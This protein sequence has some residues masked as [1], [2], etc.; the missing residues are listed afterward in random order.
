MFWFI[1]FRKSKCAQ[2]GTE[3]KE[4]FYE[5]GGKKFCCQECK[6]AYRKERKR[7]GKCH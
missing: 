6:K 1:K 4:T 2:C 5:W 3:L 7:G